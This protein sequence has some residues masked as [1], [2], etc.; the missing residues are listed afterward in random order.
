MTDHDRP[1]ESELDP[2]DDA[3]DA[4]LEGAFSAEDSA[5]HSVHG[6]SVLDRIGEIAGSKPQVLLRD[7]SGGDTPMLKPLVKGDRTQAGKYVVQGEVGRGGVGAVHRGHDQD[8]GRD[9]AMKF[10]HERYKDEPAI[11]HR[12]VEEAQIGGQLQHPGIVPVY[13]LGLVDGRPYFA[14]KLVKGRTLAKQLAERASPTDDRRDFL[15]IF[16]DVCQTMAYAHARGVV[17]RD[18]KPA[19]IMIGSFGEVQVVD[20]GMGKVLQSGGVADEKFAAER[21]AQL[22]VIETVRSSGH[23]SQSI[24][25][26]IMGTPAYMP[27]EQARGEVDAMDERSDVFALGAIL[28]ELL[29]GAPPYVAKDGTQSDLITMAATADLQDAHDRLA[30]CGAEADLVDLAKSCL[31]PAPDAR[32]RTAS[33]VAKAVHDHLAAVEAR[34]HEARLETAEA[35]IRA[36]ALKRSQRL[37]IALSIVIAAGL[38]ASLLFWRDAEEQRGIAEVA[39]EEAR[40]AQDREA[41]ARGAAEA[42]LANFNNLSHAVRLESAKSAQEDFY[43]AWPEQSAAMRAWMEGDAAQLIG[44][45]PELR[46]TIADLAARAVPVSEERRAAERE[47]HPRFAE[48]QTLRARL[49]AEQYRYDVQSGA[50][51]PLP[52]DVDEAALPRT[53]GALDHHKVHELAWTRVDPKRTEFGSEAE[54]LALARIAA[55]SIPETDPLYP[56]FLDTLAWASFANGLFDEARAAGEAAHDAAPDSRR[57]DFANNRQ[58][59]ENAIHNASGEVGRTQLDDLAA[60]IAELDDEV[61]APPGSRLERPADRFLYETLRR[62][63]VEI[64]AFERQEMH[65]VGRRLAWSEH[66]EDLTITR[67]RERWDAARLAIL[68]ADGVTASALYRDVPIDLD[69]Q[70]GLVPIGMNPVTKLWEFYHLRSA[71]DGVSDPATIEVPTHQDDGTI[72]VRAETGIVFVLLPGAT[73][74]MGAQKQDPDGPNYDPLAADFERPR[75]VAIDPFLL[76]RHEM[77]SAQWTRLWTGDE[78]GRTPSLY[79]PGFLPSQSQARVSETNPVERVSW[80]MCDETMT[81]HALTLPT[82][83]QWEYGCRAGSDAPFH[84]DAE[85]LAEFAN[86]ADQSANTGRS[87]ARFESWS[88]GYIV[89]SPVGTF[90]PNAF[91]LHDIHGNVWEWTTDLY[92]NSPMRILRGGGFQNPA[93]NARATQVYQNVPQYVAGDVGMRAARELQVRD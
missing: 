14:M 70:T 20:W 85:D 71:W 26:S 8:L 80:P 48:L 4:A 88:D 61:S 82:G 9:V 34:V 47:G 41:T 32:P 29:T 3:L 74:S 67:H 37:G 73:F 55:S 6:H 21:A 56:E 44:A 33:V 38:A 52:F 59:M 49:G 76:A 24:V 25:G 28:C 79:A 64:K 11:L 78:A 57:V 66:V 75:D 77:T 30:Q 22:S 53:D 54:G 87:S 23:G 72:E 19:N 92:L 43:P 86:V 65:S 31:A 46:G 83:A 63:V 89:H 39:A 40:E 36:L 93:D 42:N 16:E 35:K 91:G 10:L 84:C 51:A 45:L 12:F 18:L 81:R 27:P 50:R 90:R 7:D 69:P 17:H 1:A 62:L 68:R 2:L 60:R 5:T 15:G 58:W 13:D